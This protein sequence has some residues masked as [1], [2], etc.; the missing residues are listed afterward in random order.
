MEGAG[1]GAAPA[2]L[3]EMEGELR[4][5]ILT[6]KRARALRRDMTLPEVVLWEALRGSRLEGWRFRRQHPMGPYVLDFYCPSARLAVEVDGAVHDHPDRIR[7][8]ARRDEWLAKQNVRVLRV[9][10]VDV[11]D[12]RLLEGV[13]LMIAQAAKVP[14]AAGA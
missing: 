10:A 1:P 7:H 12:D 13:L 11:L 5:P 9:M 2:A 4:G 6:F 3:D 8:D 14:P